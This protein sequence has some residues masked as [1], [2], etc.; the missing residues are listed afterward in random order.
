MVAQKVDVQIQVLLYGQ[1]HR[2]D[3]RRTGGYRH[4]A[5]DIIFVDDYEEEVYL[6][7]GL[8]GRQKIG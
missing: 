5:P 8:R 4:I 1:A 2:F 6:S 3:I 7:V